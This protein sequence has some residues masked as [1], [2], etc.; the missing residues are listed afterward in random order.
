MGAEPIL[1]LVGERV[2]LGPARP[3]DL[4]PRWFNDFATARSNMAAP[5]PVGEAGLAQIADDRRS[6]RTVAFTI[7]LLHTLRALPDLRP[8]GGAGLH[9]LDL[10]N[11]QAEFY[12]TISEPSERGR[13]YGTE[14]TR[15]VLDHAFTGLGL[16]AVWLRVAAFNVAGIRAYQRAGFRQTA[17]LRDA[18]RMGGRFW[19]VILMDCL[20]AEFA[21]L[22]EPSGP[23]A[24]ISTA[25]PPR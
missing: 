4:Q 15:L 5:E 6:A 8:I 11:R 14:A 1:A 9:D 17:R 24:E 16:H 10:R 23:A 7:Y 21:V 12:I 19:D 22:R 25:D 13:G 18:Y 3:D 2:A 20:A